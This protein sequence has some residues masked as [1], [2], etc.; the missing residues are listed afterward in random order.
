M[1]FINSHLLFQITWTD[2][3]FFDKDMTE[4][5]TTGIG[6]KSKF[7]SAFCFYF[8]SGLFLLFLRLLFILPDFM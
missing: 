2:S 6:P 1:D 4:W 3:D 5:E 7:L 8:V